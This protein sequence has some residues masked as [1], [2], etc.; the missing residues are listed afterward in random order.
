MKF[1]NYFA[2]PGLLTKDS[3]LQ[4]INPKK[5]VIYK[6]VCN[7]YDV[8]YDDLISRKRVPERLIEA[9]H[10][11]FYLMKLYTTHDYSQLGRIIGR[12]RTSVMYGIKEFAKHLSYNID[13][14]KRVHNI[15]YDIMLGVVTA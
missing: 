9:R 6:A 8:S 14:Q 1:A 7:E 12:E 15:R 10:C 3:A 2:Y 13:I 4:I 5:D 11:Y